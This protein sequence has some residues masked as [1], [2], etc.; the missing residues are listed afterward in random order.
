MT[1]VRAITPADYRT[2]AII[3]SDAARQ[4]LLGR[5]HWDTAADVQHG[6]EST[7]EAEF[8]VAADPIVGV[9][10]VAGY[11]WSGGNEAKLHGPV[12][13]AQGQGA[14]AVLLSRVET[15]AR[16]RGAHSYSMLIGLEN[17]SGSAWAE[18]HG[19]QLDTEEPETL[20]TWVY[21]GELRPGQGAEMGNGSGTGPGR[22]R[23]ARPADLAAVFAM[24]QAAFPT[25]VLTQDDWSEWIHQ[26]WVLEHDGSLQAM[27]RLDERTALLHHFCVLPEARRS[28]LGAALLRGVA[29]DLWNRR[30][31]RIGVA[32]RLDNSAA[33]GFFRYMGFGGEI[34]VATWTKR[35]D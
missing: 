26:C 7:P 21:P 25:A 18:W 20:M 23:R 1:T 16:H 14:G 34:P 35:G 3:A 29:A 2:V 19:Y 33:V 4:A 17:R 10:G 5:P 24:Y 27:T 8:V 28:G 9:V 22:V 13:S 32:V 11:E 30:S 6:V 31:S 15:L 12:V